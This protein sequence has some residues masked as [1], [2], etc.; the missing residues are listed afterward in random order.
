[1]D[2]MIDSSKGPFLAKDM[3]GGGRGS[4]T[5]VVSGKLT[6]TGHPILCNDTHLQLQQ[7]SVWYLNQKSEIPWCRASAIYPFSSEEI[8]NALEW[9][10]G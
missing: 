2:E 3:E 5:W 4:N 7:P 10:Y 6:E 1:M 9:K 8:Y